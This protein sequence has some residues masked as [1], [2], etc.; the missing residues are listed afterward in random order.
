MNKQTWIQHISE[1]GGGIIA[2]SQ[3]GDKHDWHSALAM[4]K[5][6]GPCAICK[7]RI[8][9]RQASLRVNLRN[10]AMKDLGLVSYRNQSG[11]VC[12]E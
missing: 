11:T 2:P 1:V 8:K 10:Q 7:A 6:Q 4:H 5:E 3:G 12:W 9:T